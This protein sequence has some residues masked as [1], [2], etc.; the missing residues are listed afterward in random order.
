MKYK[1]LFGP[2]SSRRLGTSLGVDCVTAKTCDL[3]CIYCECG[4]TTNL[5]IER[6]EYVPAQDIIAELAAYLASHPRLDYITFG[7]S[8]EP[9]LNS[10]IGTVIRYLKKE[11]PEYKT[12]LL[13]NGTLFHLPEVRSEVM[14]FDYVLPS[15]D[16]VSPKSF[17]AVN[18]NHRELDVAVMIDGLIQFAGQYTGTIWVEVFIVPGINDTQEELARFKDVLVRM[19]PA[20]VQLNS[21][22]RPGTCSNVPQASSDRLQ[23]IAH[24]F[25]PLPVEIIARGAHLIP[26]PNIGTDIVDAIMATILRRPLSL[27]EVAALGSMTINE[28]SALLHAYAQ[29]GKLAYDSVTQKWMVP[30][31]E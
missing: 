13:T 8:G 27:E 6:K 24:Y 25:L 9:T 22:D 23:E 14:L 12:A 26:A 29:T 11:H 15:L 20:R 1:H 18:R 17:A 16:A 2:V 4:A 30:A 21:L 5:T 28:A 19:K 10:G 3:D 7:G 31:R